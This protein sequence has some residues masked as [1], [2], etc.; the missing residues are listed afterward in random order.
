MAASLIGI[1]IGGTF[2]DIVSYDEK[3]HD[4]SYLKLPSSPKPED[5]V[6]QGLKSMKSAGKQLQL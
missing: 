2:T 4:F 6:M 1:D 5:G 3:T